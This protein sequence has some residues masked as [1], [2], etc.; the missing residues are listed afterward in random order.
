MTDPDDLPTSDT[1]PGLG[2]D[3]GDGSGGEQGEDKD[4]AYERRIVALEAQNAKLGRDFQS[5]IGRLHSLIE[6]ADTGRGASETQQR[7]IAAQLEAVKST[8][9]AVLEDETMSPEIRAR[10]RA[11][12]EKA[13]ADADRASMRAELEAVKGGGQRQTAPAPTGSDFEAGLV[14]GIEAAGLS[15]DDS[16]FNWQEATQILGTQGQG[17]VQ[18]YFRQ[19]IGEGVAAKQAAERRQSRKT[20]AGEGAKPDGSTMRPLDPSLPIE[21]RLKAL[22]DMG[23]V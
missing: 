14:F 22:R 21:Q 1:D 16:I 10:A 20:A 23:I 2:D 5:G 8:L 3:A 17:A 11:A 12:A 19:K 15:P 4:A 18:A 13:E 7:Q 6:R 9:V